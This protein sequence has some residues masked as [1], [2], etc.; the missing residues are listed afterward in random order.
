MERRRSP[1]RVVTG[2]MGLTAVRSLSSRIKCGHLSKQLRD[3]PPYASNA[4]MT[5]IA[6]YS[7]MR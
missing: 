2:S 3:F 6:R 1:A 5:P 4:I 7:K